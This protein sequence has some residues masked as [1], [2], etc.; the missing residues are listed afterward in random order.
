MQ[1]EITK[2][3]RKCGKNFSQNITKSKLNSK[4]ERKFCTRKCANS[5]NPSIDK[6]SKISA[7]L[8][9][10]SN[11]PKR[12]IRISCIICSKDFEARPSDK[13]K[14]CSK[15]C[16]G[17]FH[18]RQIAGKCGGYRTK[19]GKSKFFGCYYRDIWLDSSWEL[20]FAKHLDNLKI[21]WQRGLKFFHYTDESGKLRK[22]YPDFYLPDYELYIEIKGYWTDKSRFKLHAV[23]CE[24]KI[25]LKVLES[26]DQIN[27]FM[28]T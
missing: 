4:Y 27:S 22:Y 23:K 19:S 7:G 3:C 6:N 12:R 5:R 8:I 1:I 28:L 10:N 24:N 16:S 17:S 18:K 9:G 15:I 25:E 21:S 14:T 11:N 20:A 13:R 26:L 2:E